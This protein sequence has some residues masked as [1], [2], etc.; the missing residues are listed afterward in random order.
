MKRIIRLLVIL[1]VV[2]AAVYVVASVVRRRQASPVP[3]R[4]TPRP[5]N[6]RLRP[7]AGFETAEERDEAVEAEELA[8]EIAQAES[9]GMTPPQD[10]P[11]TDIA[12]DEVGAVVEPEAVTIEPEAPTPELEEVVPAEAE[13]M[14][15]GEDEG[16]D[17]AEMLEAVEHGRD[18]LEEPLT[19]VDE[20]AATDAPAEADVVTEAFE[21]LAATPAEEAPAA[22]LAGSIEEAVAPPAP[23]ASHRRR[24]RSN[25]S[26]RWRRR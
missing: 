22:Q 14:T 1:G 2:S 10:L 7:P 13:E 8:D 24:R 26:T 20:V 17:F 5:W 12:L 18:L 23:P 6:R 4:W 21:E 3:Q 15:P 11:P 25:C 16:L 9:E 19:V